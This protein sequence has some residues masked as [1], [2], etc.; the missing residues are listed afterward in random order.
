ME[1]LGE[2]LDWH[3]RDLLPDTVGLAADVRVRLVEGD[4][5]AMARGDGFDPDRSGRRFDAILLDVDHT[6]HHHL[7][8]SHAGFYSPEGLRSMARFLRPGGTFGLWSDDPP[9]AAFEAVLAEVFTSVEAHVVDFANHL[10]GGR[11]ANTV[12]VAR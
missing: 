4:F 6:P 8:P 12:Y 1:A 5:F 7:H 9:D 2:V 10:T 11:S 3:R